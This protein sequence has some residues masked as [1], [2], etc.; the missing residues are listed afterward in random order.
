MKKL[1]LVLLLSVGVTTVC[2]AKNR[3]VDDGGAT[4][5]PDRCVT[6]DSKCCSTGDG[7]TYYGR[8]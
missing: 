1:L 6:S 2:L 7:S 8:L 4:T 3:P 5:C